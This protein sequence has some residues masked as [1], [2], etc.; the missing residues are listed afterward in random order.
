[1]YV[2]VEGNSGD[3]AGQFLGKVVC[4]RGKLTVKTDK[5]DAGQTFPVGGARTYNNGLLADMAGTDTTHM[6]G[7]VLENNVAVDGTIVAELDL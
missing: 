2:V 7:V 1:V 4:L 6:I 5:L 3:T